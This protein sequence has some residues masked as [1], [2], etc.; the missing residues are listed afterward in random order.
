MKYQNPVIKG[1][2]PDPSVIRVKNDYYLVVSSFEFFPGVPVFHSKNLVDWTLINHC[3]KR[4]TQ[5]SLRGAGNSGGIYAP[6]LR[7]HNGT[8]YMITTNVSGGGNMIVQTKDILGD[9][10]NPVYVDHQGIDPSLLFDGDTVYFTATDS[11]G[12]ALYEI[13]PDTGRLLSDKVILTRGISGKNPEAPHLYKIGPWYYLMIAEGGTEY[14][15]METIFRA[16]RPQGP[17]ES[18]PHNPVLSHRYVCDGP[19]RAV[20]HAEL[21]EDDNGNWWAAC[22]GVRIPGSQ[23]LHNLGR[24]TF[25]TPVSWDEDGW[26]HFGN[27]GTVEMET[28]APL[29]GVPQSGDDAFADSF[30]GETLASDWTFVRMR[31]LGAYT[32]TGQGL[33]LA[34]DSQTLNDPLPTAALLR[35]REFCM[36]A[37][38]LLAG[39]VAD[40]GRAGLTAYYNSEYHAEIALCKVNGIPHVRLTATVHGMSFTVSEKEVDAADKLTLSVEADGESYRF[41][42]GG[43]D[44]QREIGHCPTAMFCTEGTR[45]M[46]FTGTFF[47]VFAEN[48]Q[49]LFE[50]FSCISSEG[51]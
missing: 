37:E 7:Y 50:R 8:F 6:T 9:W 18:C 15:H 34:G 47:G 12:I 19:I 42:C 30:T 2:H 32:I 45:T 51:R 46:T 11:P 43:A 25:L 26:P 27:N 29:P 17:Y 10:S 28:N 39:G 14:G 23:L 13:D 35:Q 48:T 1:F 49:A 24:E 16:K 40:S 38:T 31:K 5:L 33:R 21:V 20:G 41:F 36:R 22:L 44:A 4:E 3:L